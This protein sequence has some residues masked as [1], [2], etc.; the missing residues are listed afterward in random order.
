MIDF[1]ADLTL[2]DDIGAL[3]FT[4]DMLFAE[5]T[6][7]CSWQQRLEALFAQTTLL[8]NACA[9]ELLHVPAVFALATVTPCNE[10]HK[11]TE[12]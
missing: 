10:Q 6:G 11:N 12:V 1:K 3:F 8:G 7:G 2:V 5:H 9:A 4:V